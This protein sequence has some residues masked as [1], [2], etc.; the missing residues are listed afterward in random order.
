MR[1]TIDRYVG[2]V[3]RR[4][5]TGGGRRVGIV[6]RP[7]ETVAGHNRLAVRMW[8]G[9]IGRTFEFYPSSKYHPRVNIAFPCKS[10]PASS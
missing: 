2:R 7:L 8:F 5:A 6:I 1:A 9:Y 4:P 3:V 10:R